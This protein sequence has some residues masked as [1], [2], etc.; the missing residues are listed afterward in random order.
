M[1]QSI[2]CPHCKKQFELSDVIKHQFEEEVR[3]AYEKEKEISN[4]E[5]AEKAANRVKEDYELKVKELK[6]ASEEEKERNKKLLATLEALNSEIRG[7]RRKDEERGLETAKKINEESQKAKEDA[8]KKANE[9]HKLKELEANKKLQDALKAN[10]EMK[11]KL[12]Q[13]SQQT[14][15]EVL[16]L[17]LE[18]VLRSHFVYDEIKEVPKGV[19]GAD[20]LH[21]VRTPRG[22]ACG[23]IIWESKRTKAWSDSWISKLKE[24]QRTAIAEQAVLI[25]EVLP[26]GIRHF[27]LVN[28]VWVCDYESIKPVA[29]MLRH[30]LI[31][32]TGAKLSHIGKNEKMEAVYEYLTGTGF[33]QR[34]EA[35]LETCKAMRDDLEQEKKALTTRW[36]KR[37]K[38]IEHLLNST[39]RTHGELQ[40]IMGKSLP[41]IKMLDI[42]E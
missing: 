15:G 32:L 14:Q 26:K 17:H 35:I 40:G 5:A 6:S 2:T 24:D 22:T 20:V 12:E 37:E 13:G 3:R 8:Y 41:E 21:I 11:R 18:N 9:E 4:K 7:L 34:V 25:S 31:Q 23:T 29:A 19:R 33:R 10:E 27:D 30:A 16:E 38:H 39:T 42:A 1:N 28:G 36:S